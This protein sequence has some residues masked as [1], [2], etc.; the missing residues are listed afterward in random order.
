MLHAND[1][2]DRLVSTELIRADLTEQTYRVLRDRILRR[3]IGVG[4]RVAVDAIADRL[5]VSRTPVTH[6]LKR[7]GSDGLV[8]IM[9]RRGTFVAG[10]TSR[11]AVELFDTRLMI[12]LHSA[13]A[14]FTADRAPAVGQAMRAPMEGM[15][16]VV[17]GDTYDDY[18]AF[19]DN[20]RLFHRAIV[21]AVGNGRLLGFYDELNVHMYVVRAHFVHAVET[22][23]HAR[24][25]HQAIHDAFSARE[26]DRARAA[27]VAH[28]NGVRDSI[29]AII[30]R[31]GGSI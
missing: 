18:E 2:S 8:E 26:A 13:D 17:T 24:G 5:G 19:I 29:L 31:H 22:A 1:V 4:E 3:E 14:I 16:A 23:G 27:L 6:A 15:A 7:L 12:E 21:A 25:E 9:P 30:D 10:I 28:I 11:D 20:D